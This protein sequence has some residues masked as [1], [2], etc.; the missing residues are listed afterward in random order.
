MVNTMVAQTRIARQTASNF[1]RPISG[2]MVRI[3][4]VLLSG[5]TDTSSPRPNKF[6]GFDTSSRG[7]FPFVSGR[8]ASCSAGSSSAS[9]VKAASS[10]GCGL[11]SSIPPFP[12]SDSS[13]T[14]DSAL[15]G[16][17]G[18]GSEG[19]F[20]SGSNAPDS[21]SSKNLLMRPFQP[22]LRTLE[23]RA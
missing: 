11:T 23:R 20:T 14:G 3:M 12:C 19:S 22:S 6:L 9:N 16:E 8:A 4:T 17:E 1:I 2:G 10:S 7:P 21:K 13:F 18:S 5:S 15:I